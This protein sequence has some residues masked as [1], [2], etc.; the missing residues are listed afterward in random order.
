MRKSWIVCKVCFRSVRAG[1]HEGEKFCCKNCH[2]MRERLS[3]IEVNKHREETKIDRLF[4]EQNKGKREEAMDVLLAVILQPVTLLAQFPVCPI[5][6][7]P[8]FLGPARPS[9]FEPV[10]L[11]MTCAR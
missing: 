7:R 11:M 4:S 5:S 6:Q 8:G 1:G 3:L 10:S 2:A 9:V